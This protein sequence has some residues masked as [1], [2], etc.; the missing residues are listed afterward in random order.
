ML[1]LL[2]S[3][4]MNKDK[5]VIRA[6]ILDQNTMRFD[7]LDQTGMEVNRLIQTGMEANTLYQNY[8]KSDVVDQ[9]YVNIGSLYTGE[10]ASFG[11]WN[12]KG[13]KIREWEGDLI[14]FTEIHTDE[15][16]KIPEKLRNAIDNQEFM[17]DAQ[18]Y[19]EYLLS[20]IHI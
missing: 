11:K 20:L 18:K 4:N 17:L 14:Y 9:S 13:A 3:D 8:M 5:L 10:E 7:I 2:L 12:L 19:M 15:N 1:L 6:N 16:T